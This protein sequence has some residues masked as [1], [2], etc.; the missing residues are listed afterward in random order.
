M[1]SEA[2]TCRIHITP[3]LIASGWDNPPYSFTE[4]KTITDGRIYIQGNR[5]QRGLQKRVD[6]LLKLQNDFPIAVIEAKAE[7]NPAGNGVQQVKDYAE[8]L[9]VK[10][11]FAT[12]GLEIIEIDYFTGQETN[13]SDF[14]TPS[15]LINRYRVGSQ[16][17][18]EIFS[19]LLTPGN[20]LTSHRLRYYQEIAVN[21]AL[22]AILQGKKRILLTLATGTGKTDVAWQICWKLWIAR[23]N[24]VGDFRRPRI[25]FLADRNVLVDDPK[26][27][28]FAPFR[29]A[30]HKVGDDPNEPNLSREMYFATYQVIA[31][32]ERRIGLF[33]QFPE[34]FFDLVIVDECHR[35]SARE[36]SS[37]RSIL[38][39]FRK[40]YQI[41]M[42]AT[43]LRDDNIDTYRYFGNPI[44]TYSLKQG[45]EDGFLAPYRVH[46]IL[47]D[48]DAF[49]WRPDKGA[50][51]RFGRQI[52]DGEY[53][54][55][56]FERLIALK[57]R[58]HAIA[59]HLTNYLVQHDGRL[60][61]TI[62]FCV[63]QEHADEMR[64]ALQNLNADL[65]QQYT[66]YVV[67][68]TA[69]EGLPGRGKLSDFQDVEKSTPVIVT[70]SKLLTT[71][72]DIPTCRNIVIARVINS[73]TEFKQ[74]IGRGTRVRDDYGK[75]SFNILDYTGSATRLF[76][77]PDFDGM[78]VELTEESISGDGEVI[79]ESEVVL[80]PEQPIPDSDS[81]P[82]QSTSQLEI[83]D[84]PR[85]KFYF[86]GGQVEILSHIVYELDSE[87]NQLSVV[88][89]TEYAGKT[90][91]TLYPNAIELKNWWANPRKRAEIIKA[92]SERGIE[93]SYLAEATSQPDADP[94]DL[95]CF[96][97]YNAPIRSRRERVDRVKQEETDFFEK[98][99]DPARDILEQ[100]LNKYA[101]YGIAEFKLPEVL[102]NPPISDF[103]NEIEISSLFGGPE[104]LRESVEHLQNLLYEE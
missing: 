38:E 53:Q 50:L 27:K 14:P 90:V 24:S 49:G 75:L 26:D 9:G 88:K 96:L 67:R 60:E 6:Y 33:R 22:Q 99:S 31:E 13:R 55:A 11:A 20:Y 82:Y 93:F 39:Y 30:R 68:I 86:D 58:T 1:P 97:A 70:T 72:V 57:A 56:D 12:N 25:L 45:I 92:L 74:I 48:Y 37:W 98:F 41:G 17:D 103:G 79:A 46:R 65:A 102:Q 52:P 85:R 69:D 77:D 64:R 10:F 59:K 73:M 63:D 61:K 21:R 36:E 4:Q 28:A 83:A 94:F 42:T 51:D 16:L 34:D 76:A 5:T 7:D 2:D 80:E 19:K 29:D 23:W 35:G 101:D 91:R 54:T 3:K 87:G 62:V 8:M 104:L 71:G 18:P 47:T 40:A 32:D 100:L 89:L 66:D 95:I 84:K 81:L 44:Y 43:P 78:P 15:E